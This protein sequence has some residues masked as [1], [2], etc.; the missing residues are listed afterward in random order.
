LRKLFEANGMSTVYEAE[1]PHHDASIYLLFVGAREP[2]RYARLL[3][4]R[5][6]REAGSWIGRSYINSGAQFAKYRTGLLL[7]RIRGKNS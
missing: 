7:D 1:S 5:R 2:D 6:I 3:P 4:H